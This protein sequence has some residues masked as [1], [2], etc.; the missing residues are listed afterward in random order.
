MKTSVYTLCIT[1]SFF[2]L[3]FNANASGNKNTVT[4]HSICF[5]DGLYNWNITFTGSG[6]SYACT[7]TVYVN[8]TKWP[9]YG[10]GDFTGRKGTVDLHAINPDGDGCRSGY[11]D[12][13]T[14]S[15]TA[16]ITD[17]ASDASFRIIGTFINYCSGT[18]SNTGSW[19][20]SGPCGNSF[21]PQAAGAG[22]AKYADIFSMKV[23]PNPVK[24]SSILT[25]N[26]TK[27]SQVKITVFNYMQQPV[28]LVV[29][30]KETAGTHN[31]SINSASLT[32]GSYRVVAIVDG[33]YYTYALQV[34]K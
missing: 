29:D 13:F 27:T 14:C 10:S 4:S 19:S 1:L 32:S 23:S 34:A 17:T 20:A 31:Y 25:Y 18:V 15:G 7:G 28:Q 30:K 22:P 12:S 33:K 9:V 24:N 11:V 2:C 16:K 21:T 6:G 26:L 8:N 3:S 5:N